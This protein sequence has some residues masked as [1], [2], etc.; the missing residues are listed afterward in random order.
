MS[1]VDSIALCSKSSNYSHTR[2]STDVIPSDY[3]RPRLG[4]RAGAAVRAGVAK[5]LHQRSAAPGRTHE[6]DASKGDGKGDR[7]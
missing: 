4:K 6:D 1:E 2:F 7:R 5:R 3:L